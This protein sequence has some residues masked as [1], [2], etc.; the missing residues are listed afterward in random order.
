[1]DRCPEDRVPPGSAVTGGGAAYPCIVDPIM[2]SSISR[3]FVVLAVM[4]LLVG[5]QSD[6]AHEQDPAFTNA[7]MGAAIPEQFQ[8]GEAAFNQNCSACHGERGLGTNQGPPLVHIIYEPAHHGDLAFL[9]AVERG[10]RAHHWGFGD[11]PPVAGVDRDQVVAI[12]GYIRY[13]QRQVG[14]G[15]L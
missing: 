14:I 11:M 2:S 13:L 3:S 9:M 8:A 12:I 7:V 6:S 4:L 15:L 10:V 1:M 5:C